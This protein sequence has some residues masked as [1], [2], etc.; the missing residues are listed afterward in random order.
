MKSKEKNIKKEKNKLNEI[1]NLSNKS[2]KLNEESLNNLSNHPKKDKIKFPNIYSNLNIFTPTFKLNTNRAK[3]LNL[4]MKK[5]TKLYVSSKPKNSNNNN[6]DEFNKDNVISK[7]SKRDLSNRATTYRILEALNN[8]S[9][10]NNKLELTK[11]N[12]SKDEKS[13]VNELTKKSTKYLKSINKS[14]PSELNKLKINYDNLLTEKKSNLNA[15]SENNSNNNTNITTQ[16]KSLSNRYIN[17]E[18]TNKIIKL[19]LNTSKDKSLKIILPNQNNAKKKS[20]QNFQTDSNYESPI[21]IDIN[22]ERNKLQKKQ[23]I[24]LKTIKLYSRNNQNLNFDKI[25]V[26]YDKN[27][28]KNNKKIMIE[29]KNSCYCQNKDFSCPEE[30]H[31]YYIHTIQKGKKN[32]NKF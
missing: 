12:L 17:T 13:L 3:I 18:I 5:I 31:F 2:N 28:S 1:S 14:N 29:S 22:Q 27:N 19:N 4:N 11:I 10:N 20:I 7:I 9:S 8:S 25:G 21:R 6:S 24:N 15:F 32:E 26:S 23:E 16:R 30:L